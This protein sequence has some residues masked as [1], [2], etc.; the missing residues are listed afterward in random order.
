[1]AKTYGKGKWKGVG[2]SSIK[3]LAPITYLKG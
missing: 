2:A 3:E 1:M